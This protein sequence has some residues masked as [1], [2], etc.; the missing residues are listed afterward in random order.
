M[1]AVDGLVSGLNTSSI[2][3]QLVQ[4][5]AAPQDRL[6]T[7]VT[8]AQKASTGYQAVNTKMLALK[9]AAEALT[10]AGGWSPTSVS[11]TSTS[12]VATSSGTALTGS[13]SFTV[14]QLAANRS[15]LSQDGWADTTSGTASAGAFSV[16]D[17]QGKVLANFDSSTST[18]GQIVTEINGSAANTAV[19]AAAVKTADGSYRL[20]L[21]ATSSGTAGNFTLKS[22]NGTPPT[23]GSTVSVDDGYATEFTELSAAKDAV[24]NLVKGSTSDATKVVSSTNTF[25]DVM[26]GV[27]LTVSATTSDYVTV[28]ANAAP[29]KVADSVKALVDAANAALAEIANQSKA[30]AIGANGTVTGAGALRGDTTLRQLQSQVVSAV[31]YALAGGASAGSMGIQST[32]EGTLTFDRTKFLEAYA[33]DPDGVREKL[34][35]TSV[36]PTSGGEGVVERLLKVA[37]GASSS[38]GSLTKAAKGRDD[39]VKELN[40]RIAEWDDRLELKRERY[41][42]YYSRLETM[43]GSLQSQSSWL[44]GQLAN[45]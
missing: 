1:A 35:P 21:T 16:L 40:D 11:S 42:K 27:T 31:T 22:H 3:S 17:A 12:V 30:G 13:T 38:S 37:E 41:Q 36:D 7:A 9:T 29:D 25:A 15:L 45:L 14:D 19:R 4:L 8:T 26:P 32:K 6:K 20:Q 39:A 24:L 44:S 2:I 34:A 18:L 10:K 5:D 33:D 28:S 43:L 23:V